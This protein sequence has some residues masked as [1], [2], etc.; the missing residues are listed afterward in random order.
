MLK[1][2]KKFTVGSLRYKVTKKAVKGKGSVSIAGVK[3]KTLKSVKIAGTVSYKGV[4]YKITS[5]DAKAFAKCKKLKK[6]TITGKYLTKVGKNALKGIHKKCVIR[7]PK[8]KLKK[9]KKIFKRKGQAKTVKI[10]KR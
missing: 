2:G 3:K 8:S 7:V 1:K 10:R 5:I 4:K 6:I 9:Y